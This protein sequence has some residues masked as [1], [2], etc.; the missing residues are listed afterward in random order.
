MVCGALPFDGNNLQNLRARVLAGRFR[1][2]FYMTQGTVYYTFTS[3]TC[4]ILCVYVCFCITIHV[5]YCM[6]STCTSC[7][8]ASSFA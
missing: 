7:T 8:C 3:T 4:M 2:P 5:H 1:I 6:Y